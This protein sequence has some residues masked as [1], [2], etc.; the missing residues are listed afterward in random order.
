MK[1]EYEVNLYKEI[2]KFRLNE[3]VEVKNRKGIRSTIHI[4]NITKLSWQQLQLLVSG[5]VDRFSKMVLLYRHYTSP[6][7]DYNIL[8]G[9]QLSDKESDEIN[10]YVEI[11]KNNNFVKHH[12][13]NSYISENKLWDI[14]PTIRSMN[15]HGEEKIVAGIQPKYFE[16]V[17]RILNISGDLGSPLKSYKPY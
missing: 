12:E 9:T 11:Y 15:D 4:Q 2:A 6:Q 7:S 13:I 3:I 16:I 17:C 5:G 10:R 8:R 14:F 1:I